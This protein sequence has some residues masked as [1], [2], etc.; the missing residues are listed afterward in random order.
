[1]AS[2]IYQM[3]LSRLGAVGSGDQGVTMRETWTTFVA[4]MKAGL[5][6]L[7]FLILSAISGIII[8]IVCLTPFVLIGILMGVRDDPPWLIPV[9]G[10]IAAVFWILQLAK[11]RRG[12]PSGDDPFAP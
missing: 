8:G 5:H 1:M 6:V 3:A 11:L 4:N 10:V 2:D 12:L 9:A 7:T